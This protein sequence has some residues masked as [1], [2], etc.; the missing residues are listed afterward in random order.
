MATRSRRLPFSI[1]L[2]VLVVLVTGVTGAVL[3][4]L[5]WREKRA[6]ARA[7]T[8]LAMEQAANLT[9]D[10]ILRLFGDVEPA[11]RQGPLLVGQGLLDPGN[12]AA[13]ERYVVAVL[14]AH[15]ELAWA[16]YGDRDDRFVGAWR[17]RSGAVFVNRSF[18]RGVLIRL[19]EDRLHPD[20]RRERV[21][22]SDDH[23]YRP[24]ERPF[25]QVA[26][27]AGDVAWT[28]P[29]RFFEGELGITCAAPLLEAGT[30]RGVFTV[31]L[32]LARLSRFVD[33]LKLTPR[34]RVFVTTPSGDIVVGPRPE[35]PGP[36]DDPRLVADAVRRLDEPGEPPP[37]IDRGGER[38]LVR[39]L[40]ILAG[41]REWR[42]AVIVPER[43]FT[44]EI[45]AQARRTAALA[46]VA[47]VLA[48]A[49]GI[50]FSRWI[51]RPLRALS[52]Q[53]ERI[54]DGDL[55]VRIVPDS[56][57]EIGALARTLGDM[58][59]GLRDRDFIRGVLGRYVSPDVAQHCLED[60]E[61]LRLGGDVRTVSIL[62]SDLR[63]FSALS[64]RLGPEQM[65][66]LLNRYF[67]RMVPVILDHRGTINEF[68]GDAIL[69]L[70]GAPVERPDDAERAVRCAWAMQ[71]TMTAFN[72]ESRG[73]GLPELTM[74]IGLHAGRVVAGNIG[75]AD[76][77]KYGVVGPPVN[78][79][80]RIESLTVGPQVL[81]SREMVERVGSIVRVGPPHAETLKGIAEPVVVHELLG[82]VGEEG[83]PAPS[84]VAGPAADVRLLAACYPVQDK[85]VLERA[86]RV[87]VTR[88]GL[89]EVAFEA[90]P[91]LPAETFDVKLV[92]DFEDGS[93][94][95]GSYAR[96]ATR[97]GDRVAG[98]FTALDEADRR[99]IVACLGAAGR[100]N[101]L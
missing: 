80:A 100:T 2:V 63:G 61:A 71:R 64:E 24:R 17:N 85:R 14:R 54:R 51:G 66:G 77:V 89:E 90:G 11:V 75:S 23:D 94:G 91:D 88:L 53:A 68:I 87:T 56:R 57:D 76:R 26:V 36:A 45:D 10:H 40:R 70:F 49:A 62:M 33:D 97:A 39:A 19:E 79:A 59:Q 98:V 20:G 83:V 96:V 35:Q 22:V 47:L 73:L 72:A 8:D 42:V 99:R 92:I 9:A 101:V 81:L 13:L 16:S 27:A 82:I 4:G 25:Y 28:D 7:F 5:A 84:A 18:P 12:P 34:G 69:V 21:R 52:A 58:V 44:A 50:A 37:A 3:G 78:L 95:P 31:D 48:G 1:A 93:P 43:D 46:G 67:S 55:D 86:Y 65:I 15:P 60:R 29:Y 6:S 38:L 32:S 41:R 74:G 30:V